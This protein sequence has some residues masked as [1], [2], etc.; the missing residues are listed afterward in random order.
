MRF[1]ARANLLSIA[2]WSSQ[3][4]NK[5]SRTPSYPRPYTFASN[6]LWMA[7]LVSLILSS[8]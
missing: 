8:S 6:A 7:Q 5:V 1:T 2:H 3:H 4:K